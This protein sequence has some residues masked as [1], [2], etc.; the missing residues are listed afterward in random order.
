MPEPTQP[1]Q[2]HVLC[3]TIP[4]YG[5]IIPLLEFAKKI[6]AQHHVTFIV[7][8]DKMEE[9]R[10]RE[11]L[12]TEQNNQLEVLALNDGVAFQFDKSV[13]DLKRVL[14]LVEQ[15]EPVMTSLLKSLPIHNADNT[16]NGILDRQNGHT[17][18]AIRR[19]VDAIVLD[20]FLCSIVLPI[21]IQLGIPG[22]VFN[23]SA[24]ISGLDVTSDTPAIPDGAAGDGALA[25]SA[26]SNFRVYDQ[27]LTETMKKF[28]L[29]VNNPLPLASAILFNT[30]R[31]ADETAL[32]TISVSPRTAHIPVYCVGPL[33]PTAERTSSSWKQSM[34]K[35]IVAWM[36][37]QEVKSVVY[38][39]FGSLAY[40]DEDQTR[41]LSKALLMLDKAFILSM[42]KQYQSMLLEEL[43]EGMKDQF[44]R[45]DS[46]FLVLPWA[47]QKTVLG[48][49][50]C[51]VFITHA[52]WNSTL[53][54]IVGGVPMVAWPMFADQPLNGQWMANKGLAV[55]IPNT[56]MD[57]GR[58]VPAEE[59]VQAVRWSQT[60]EFQ[61]NIKA[62]Q[63]K[64]QQA[65]A[66]GGRTQADVSSFLNLLSSLPEQ[67]V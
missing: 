29:M 9:I 42:R 30:F 52:G 39:S 18:L 22:C 11:V 25:S 33:F 13:P 38:V 48:H 60:G 5:H 14:D 16:S 59:I 3:L 15:M 28:L 27:P 43:Q 37:K 44:E 20:R 61:K 4:A 49:E 26:I 62:M 47:P 2:K 12:T 10:Q 51:A 36:D 66:E 54:G 17:A 23:C 53:E 55:L 50:A 56:R 67:F 1:P 45:Q 24:G 7:S 6:S 8:S 63:I 31:E 19:P 64:A 40:L 46:R 58:V 35:K 41:E 34:E 57:G 21:C 32:K 65:V